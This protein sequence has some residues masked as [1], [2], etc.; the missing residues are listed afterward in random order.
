[1][2]SPPLSHCVPLLSFSYSTLLFSIVAPLLLIL[3]L[4]SI[5]VSVLLLL[6]PT[7]H[8]LFPSLYSSHISSPLSTIL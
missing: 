1:M 6:S 4:S 7:Y 5:F 8:I 2:S 3:L